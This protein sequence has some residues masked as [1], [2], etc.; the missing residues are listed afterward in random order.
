MSAIGPLSAS[1]SGSRTT[2][3]I[4]D[5]VGG[6]SYVLDPTAGTVRETQVAS[7]GP[8]FQ[9]GGP[10]SGARSAPRPRGA[11]DATFGSRRGPAAQTEDLGTQ[12]IQGVS[13]QGKRVTRT[14]PVGQAGNDRA[15]DIVTE[16][17]FSPD[18]QVVVMSKTGDPRFGDSV[19]RLTNISRVEPDPAQ[20]TVPSGYTVQQ[21]RTGR[22]PRPTQ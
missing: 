7:K 11:A 1:G 13:A 2:V 4:H 19:Y 16:T 6:M 14:I 12:V 18:L 9:G 3:F 5:P 10:G 21:G 22:G 8:R 20:F 15:L 17:W